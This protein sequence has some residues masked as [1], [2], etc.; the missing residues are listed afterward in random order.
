MARSLFPREPLSRPL[1]VHAPARPLQ[2]PPGSPATASIFF[3]PVA[4]VI[5]KGQVR[6]DRR[7]ADERRM[8]RQTPDGGG[9]W[10]G[11]PCNRRDSPG[12]AIWQ[13]STGRLSERWTLANFP[14]PD[15]D[16]GSMCGDNI[17]RLYGGTTV[18]S[19]PVLLPQPPPPLSPSAAVYPLVHPRS[20]LR[21]D[22]AQ[23]LCPALQ[24]AGSFRCS[25]GSWGDLSSDEVH[26]G[27]GPWKPLNVPLNTYPT[28]VRAG[29]RWCRAW[30]GGLT[31]QGRAGHDTSKVADA[32]SS[33]FI[34]SSVRV[35]GRSMP[36]EGQ[37]SRGYALRCLPWI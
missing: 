20:I 35:A 12:P 23:P 36:A 7:R 13:R 32:P 31:A 26:R 24:A 2:H 8:R 18:S 17:L 15:R 4:G 10:V 33:G 37:T 11:C 29:R 14:R 25:T 5:W 21:V 16:F 6:G 28:A 9:R 27:A 1:S 22:G 30:A 34:D 3:F 19:P